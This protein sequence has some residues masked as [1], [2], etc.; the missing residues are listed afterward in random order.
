[1]I[2]IANCLTAA[3]L[4]ITL[5]IE[6]IRRDLR[7]LLSHYLLQLSISFEGERISL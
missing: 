5:A 1:M 3:S 6:E 7:I 2:S 4:D